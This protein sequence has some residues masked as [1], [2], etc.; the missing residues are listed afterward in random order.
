MPSIPPIPAASIRPSQPKPAAAT[1]GPATPRTGPVQQ[2]HVVQRDDRDQ[3]ER[4]RSGH[5]ERERQR[6]QVDILARLQ[7]RR[8][9][10]VAPPVVRMIGAERG[11]QHGHRRGEQQHPWQVAQA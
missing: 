5:P 8:Y 10:P 11:Q 7:Q 3:R 4:S 1:L 9:Q 2:I 6:G